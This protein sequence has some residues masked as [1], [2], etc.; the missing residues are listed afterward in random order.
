MFSPR[1][2]WCRVR[3]KAKVR[4]R[5]AQNGRNSIQFIPLRI[6]RHESC[7]LDKHHTPRV[8]TVLIYI[9]KINEYLLYID[10]G[11]DLETLKREDRGPQFLHKEKRNAERSYARLK[12]SP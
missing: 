8:L 1:T 4:T 6:Q 5:Y 3:R 2:G 9:V 10:P 7:V 12:K 11:M